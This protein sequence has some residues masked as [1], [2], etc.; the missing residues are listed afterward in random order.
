[1]KYFDKKDTVFSNK[2]ECGKALSDLW[3]HMPRPRKVQAEDQDS[4]RRRGKCGKGGRK[5][6]STSLLELLFLQDKSIDTGH[7]D[8]S[9][10]DGDD[11]GEAEDRDEN[12]DGLPSTPPTNNN[13]EKCRGPTQRKKALPTLKVKFAFKLSKRK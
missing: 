4:Q 2:K 10:S 3:K 5:A 8:L 6:A 13:V 12:D 9:I 7:F 11:E 1:M